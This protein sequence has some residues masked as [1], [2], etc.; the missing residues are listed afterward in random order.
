MLNDIHSLHLLFHSVNCF[1]IAVYTSL[2]LPHI[3][4][5]NDFVILLMQNLINL[6]HATQFYLICWICTLAYQESNRTG[7]IIHKIRLNCKPV[8]LD[9]HE[10]S[11]Q[12]SLELRASMEDSNSE[13]SSYCTCCDNPY[14]VEN[15]MR[16]NLDLECVTKEVNNFSIQL[17]QN[18]V[19]HIYSVQFLRIKQYFVLLC[20]YMIYLFH[21]NFRRREAFFQFAM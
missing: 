13:Q 9:K 19:A 18:R 1:I 7:R 11:N 17:Q 12:S 10:A 2:Y 16:R 3:S 6:A 21:Y 14:C 4:T 15:F 5:E 8:N 20:E